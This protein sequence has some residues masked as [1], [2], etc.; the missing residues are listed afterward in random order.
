MIST[1]GRNQFA[2]GAWLFLRALAVVHFI[3]FASVWVQLAGLIG[4]DGILPAGPFLAAVREHL[5]PAAFWQLP[6]LC[7]WLGT[8]AALPLLCAVGLVSALLLFAGIAP[9]LNLVILWLGYLS[10]C[11]VGQTFFNFQWD[12]LLLETTFLSIWLAPWRWLPFWHHVEP[13]PLARWLLVWLLFRLMFLSGA[14]KLT[15]G[16]PTWANLTALTVHYETQPL[17]TPLGWYAHQLPV[18]FHRASCALMFVIELVVPFFF[19][20][21][22]RRVR[23]AAALATL[24]LMAAIALTGNY[25]FFN[26]LTAALCLPLLDDGIWSRFAWRKAPGQT[27][28]L[29]RH[30][31]GE[32][33]SSTQPTDE[34]RGSPYLLRPVA[35]FVLIVT[36]LQAGPS[37][38]SRW[39][40]SAPTAAVLDA[41]APFRTLNN[42][43]LFRVMTTTRAEIVIEGS[44]DGRTWTAYEFRDKPGDLARRP[45]W[46]APHQPRLDWQMWFAALGRVEHNRWVLSLCDHL[47]KNTP[48]VTALLATNPFADAPPT[49]LRAVRYEYH[50]TTR[51]ERARTGRWWRRTPVDYYLAPTNLRRS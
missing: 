23:H 6:T 19:F 35:A 15:S 12:A 29:A 4:P 41:V 51:E 39:Q 43:G 18:W 22:W 11:G 8:G 33:G 37:L 1:A 49:H 34:G 40:L 17:P 21:P 13:A 20:A 5:G 9:A 50:F 46:V 30:S 32:G 27:R 42:Y 45:T 7:W 36:I 2:V 47:L 3:A 44:R 25:T 26:L 31:L 14:V 48:A 24:A 16:D 28:K 38:L 10:L